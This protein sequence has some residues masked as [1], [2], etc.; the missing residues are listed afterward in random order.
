MAYDLDIYQGATFSFSLTLRDS[1]DAPIDVTNLSVSG[2]LKQKYS[3]TG[4]AAKFTIDKL[5]PASGLVQ[6]SLSANQTTQLPINLT[7]YDIK[8]YNTSGVVTDVLRGKV[9]VYPSTT[10]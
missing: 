1:D 6:V 10:L 5:T 9:S 2:F 7:L 4:V 8:T 3:D